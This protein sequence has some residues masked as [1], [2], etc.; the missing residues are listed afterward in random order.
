[1]ILWYDQTLSRA[2]LAQSAR[3]SS[4]SFAASPPRCDLAESL[5]DLMGFI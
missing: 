2:P 4:D 1:M 3:P 5:K